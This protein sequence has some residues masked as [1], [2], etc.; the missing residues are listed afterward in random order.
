MDKELL[1]MAKTAWRALPKD[2]RPAVFMAAVAGVMVWGYFTKIAGPI[3]E[4]HAAGVVNTTAIKDLDA[5]SEKR[6]Q[7]DQRRFTAIE[8][9]QA[10]QRQQL[11]DVA[12]QTSIILQVLLT[13][14]KPAQKTS[15][16]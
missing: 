3:S 9:N 8:A 1:D 10:E 12:A 11:K 6:H 5:K 16:K 15:H 2:W 13:G 4:A 7:E 14:Q